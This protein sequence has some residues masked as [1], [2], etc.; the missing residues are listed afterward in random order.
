[1]SLTKPRAGAVLSNFYDVVFN[2][3]AWGQYAH[4]I[5]GSW[6]LADFFVLGV[7][8]LASSAQVRCR[9]LPSRLQDGCPFTLVLFTSVL[10]ISGDEQGAKSND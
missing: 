7:S 1:M 4:T 5:L 3:F 10:A 2:G 9:F 8:R 6:A